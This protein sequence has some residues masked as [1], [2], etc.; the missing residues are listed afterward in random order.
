MAALVTLEIEGPVRLWDL[1]TATQTAL[2]REDAEKIVAYG[3]SPDGNTIYTNDTESVVRFWATSDGR[4]LSKSGLRNSR[5][6]YPKQLSWSEIVQIAGFRNPVR[7]MN[8]TAV[9]GSYNVTIAKSQLSFT[10]YDHGP[11]ELIDLATGRIV[12]RL[13]RPGHRLRRCQSSPYG[14][15]IVAV[16][17]DTQVVIFSATDGREAGRLVHPSNTWVRDIDISPYDRCILTLLRPREGPNAEAL[18]GTIRLWEADPW[19]RV[20]DA[21]LDELVGYRCDQFLTDDV[22]EI[23]WQPPSDVPMETESLYRIG[24]SSSPAPSG[25]GYITAELG[26]EL[27]RYEETKLLD[28]ESFRRLRR[29]AG[30]RF[31]PALKRLASDGRFYFGDEQEIIDTATEK[32][33]PLAWSAS[34]RPKYVS[35]FGTV[36]TRGWEVRILPAPEYLD[37]P[38][39][40]LE[41]WAQV[42][43]RGHLDDEGAFVPC[44]GPTWEKKR[45]ELASKPIPRPGFP[46][47]G[48][49]AVDGGYWLRQEFEHAND[50]DKRRLA[51]QLLERANAAG[52]KTEAARWIAVLAGDLVDSL[53]ARLLLKADV[54]DQ[55]RHDPS[56]NGEIRAAALA[57]SAQS[58]ENADDLN[59]RS[60]LVATR[61]NAEKE[62]YRRAL[63]WAE[64]A[65][66][67][68]PKNWDFVTTQGL[69]Q[70]RNGLCKESIATLMRSHEAHRIS[71]TGPHPSDLA[72]LAMAHHALGE[73]DK[74][75]EYF[76][77]L[78]SLCDQ[79]AWKE[80]EEASGFLK[81]A[82]QRL[83]TPP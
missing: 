75:H 82:R 39:D 31:H 6:V 13:D 79:P 12:A 62:E 1:R 76:R 44:D 17:D 46:F 67:H 38:P 8:K 41:L 71:E 21:F 18:K 32:Q 49:V 37:L 43:V 54:E 48:H 15:W 36:A 65:V 70:Y 2:L 63:R 22:I 52:D 11:A 4:F 73:F 24:R 78:T 42:V 25:A 68:V 61:L 58:G 29:P 45:Q 9:V 19:R 69:L 59:F 55:L 33:I 16:E 7:M 34:P 20:P 30:R 60:W 74:A 51:Q 14:R 53:A 57:Q 66:R 26:G 10:K 28:G 50:A 47:P 77:Q 3:F 35:G 83:A 23:R 64:A 81:E 27:L 80:D 40:L 56:L 5:F 72:F